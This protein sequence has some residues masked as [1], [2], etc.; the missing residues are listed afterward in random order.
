MKDHES[1]AWQE[2]LEI[3]SDAETVQAVHKADEELANGQTF[4]FEQVFGHAQPNSDA[5]RN[6]R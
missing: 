6:Q 2:T 4:S 3:F 5:P 1:E